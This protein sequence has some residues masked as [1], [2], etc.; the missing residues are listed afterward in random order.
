MINWIKNL[1]SKLIFKEVEEIVDAADDMNGR[2]FFLVELQVAD[3]VKM[4]PLKARM[5]DV[6]IQNLAESHPGVTVDAVKT[7]YNR[8]K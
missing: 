5:E 8:K 6:L 1:W 4:R 7:F 2:K 3:D